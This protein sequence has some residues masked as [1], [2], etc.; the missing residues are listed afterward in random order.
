V[1]SSED[2]RE[3]EVEERCV[4]LHGCMHGSGRRTRE[5]M[6]ELGGDSWRG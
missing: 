4:E 2:E 3:E 6:F 1:F 5:V